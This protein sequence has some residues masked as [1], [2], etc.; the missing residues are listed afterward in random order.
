MLVDTRD[1]VGTQD[2]ADRLGVEKNVVSN[3]K[4]RHPDFPTPVVLVSAGHVSVYL[5]SEVQGWA[6]AHGK[7][8][9]R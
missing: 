3:W 5:W 9:R 8:R 1:L 6:M 7:G 2:I 4:K